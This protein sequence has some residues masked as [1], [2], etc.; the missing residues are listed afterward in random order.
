MTT[1]I[2]AVLLAAAAPPQQMDTTVAARPGG[3]VDVN[4][5]GGRVTLRS[6]DRDA[7]RVRATLHDGQ[8]VDVRQRG[9][10][11]TIES[12]HADAAALRSSYEVMVPR[13]YGV[14]VEGLNL[15][16]DVQGV[17]GDVAIENIEGAIV[18]RSVT[19]AVRVE[20]VAGEMTV[21]Q[22]TGSVA[23]N[24]VNQNIRLAQV[25]GDVQVEAV[26]GS[27]IM[28]GMDAGRVDA[29]TVNGIIEYDG[30][31]HDG[32][33]YALRTHNGRI[34]MSVPEAASASISV[35]ARSGSVET[36]FPVPLASTRG[37]RVSFRVGGG[38]AVVDLQSFNG[39]VRLVRPG[40]R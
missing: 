15:A 35:Q 28:R 10:D 6:W 1:M 20:S 3:R 5:M 37:Q 26:N 18:V 36:A 38:S 32:G 11:V 19:G 23:A 21:E 16:V 33:R 40:S 17:T 39:T 4:V 2:L 12:L 27:V 14:R 13:S 34:T 9:G 31:I 8:R 7:V 25:R 24:S 30:A 22:V 29:S